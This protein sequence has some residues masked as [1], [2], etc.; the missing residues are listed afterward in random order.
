M[1]SADDDV[2]W[3]KKMYQRLL[4]RPIYLSHTRFYIPFAMSL[5]RRFMRRLREAHL[6]ATPRPIQ[7]LKGTQER[8]T[9]FKRN[10]NAIVEAYIDF[11]YAGLVM[12]RKLTIGYCTFL[13]GNLVTWN[14]E[15][16]W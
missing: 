3:I 1:G 9:L 10:K 11:D 12:D 15:K 16:V 6:Q 13:G 5:V 4:G 8:W 14:T 2:A 7:Y